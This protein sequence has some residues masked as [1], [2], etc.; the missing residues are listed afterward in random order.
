MIP[1]FFTCR[2]NNN[3]KFLSRLHFEE[4]EVR[5]VPYTKSFCVIVDGDRHESTLED[6][7]SECLRLECNVKKILVNSFT[8]LLFQMIL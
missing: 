8:W 4:S 2:Q 7:A 6:G 1:L 3:N 5:D